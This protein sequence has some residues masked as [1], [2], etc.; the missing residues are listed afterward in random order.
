MKLSAYE[1]RHGGFD[2]KDSEST[3]ALPLAS[4]RTRE[5][6]E[7][8]ATRYNSQPDLLKAC[9]TALALLEDNGQWTK[10]ALRKAIAQAGGVQ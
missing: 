5:M 7:E 4:A 2:L 10:D 6:A 3:L 1:N 9:K 8:I